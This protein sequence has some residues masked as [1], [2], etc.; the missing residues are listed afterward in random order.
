MAEER[1]QRRQQARIAARRP[2]VPGAPGEVFEQGRTVGA[3]QPA[4]GAIAPA[5][6]AFE[7]AAVAVQRLLRQPAF[8]PDRVDEGLDRARI[9][10]RQRRQGCGEC[11][12]VGWG[13]HGGCGLWLVACGLW[14]ELRL[15]LAGWGSRVAREERGTGGKAAILPFTGECARRAG[16][17]A[18]GGR[19][20]AQ[21]RKD[22]KSERGGKGR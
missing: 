13:G 6:K 15:R 7:V 2:A 11:A 21:A 16:T 1:P 8:G 20:G 19:M 18:G 10:L 3:G 5:R 4:A 22:R 14:L 17:P 12:A 9:G